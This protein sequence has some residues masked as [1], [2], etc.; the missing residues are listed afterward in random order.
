[1]FIAIMGSRKVTT[2]LNLLVRKTSVNDNTSDKR[3]LLGGYMEKKEIDDKLYW[4]VRKKGSHLVQSRKQM[5]PLVAFN[6]K[7]LT[8]R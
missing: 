4:V 8:I 2:N 3:E 5:E 1:M 7:M 6:L